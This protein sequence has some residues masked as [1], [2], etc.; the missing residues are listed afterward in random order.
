[1][2]DNPWS[3]TLRKW[4]TQGYPADEKGK[5]VDPVGHFHFDI[6]GMAG[7]D[8]VAKPGVREII[9]E[10]DAWRIVRDGN[11]AAFKW[12]KN[13]SGTPEHVDFRMTSRE[14]W[15]RDY[16]PHL[17]GS[18]R[19]RMNAEKVLRAR[20]DL[21]RQHQ[22]ERSVRFGLRGIWENM[23]AAFGDLC[24][25]ESMLTDPDWIR[26]YCRVYTDLYRE[27][28]TIVFTEA[29]LP[30]AV[31][32]YDD[33]G[34]K[35]TTFCAPPLYG[36]LLFPFYQE[37]NV[38]LHGHGLPVVLHTCGYTESVMH[39]VV[40]AGFD[41]VNPME[42]KA[43]NDPLRMADKWR[44]RIAFVGGLDA[45]ILESKDRACIRKGVTDLLE[46]M[47]RRGAG[48]V[49]GSDHS[50]STNVDYGDFRYAVEVYREHCA[51]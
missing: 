35:Y 2:S 29:G 11:G 6:A 12:W 42:V 31:W 23:R 47:K 16:R 26:D 8:W 34:Y 1:V 7:F 49:F 18:A 32:V 10:T 46:G 24:L 27:C 50:I 41:V 37:L 48:Y 19:Q 40:E 38:F 25:Y 33:L 4:L 5:P 20:A 44:E 22:Q 3:D 21:Q 36:K 39:L 14:A 28:C 15:E 13:K 30:D 17:V 43:G 45:R 9:Q 51:C